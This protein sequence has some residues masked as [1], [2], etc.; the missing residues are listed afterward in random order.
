MF[1]DIFYLL[2]K[3]NHV[4]PSRVAI[5]V[6]LNKSTV[7]MWKKHRLSPNSDALQRIA[8]YFQVPLA[9][10]LGTGPFR[11]WD[12]IN[13]NRTLFF[14]ALSQEPHVSPELMPGFDLG[15]P[16]AVATA[17]LARYIDT[18]V[19]DVDWDPEQGFHV[20]VKPILL[21]TPAGNAVPENGNSEKN[22]RIL[23]LLQQQPEAVQT[24]VLRMLE[25]APPNNEES[26]Q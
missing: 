19:E 15:K 3:E 5:D 21:G 2:C 6:G 23:E 25:G 18:V 17:D 20:A 24:M 1:F 4:A 22:N 7:S 10:L 9:F 14:E 8:D 16:Q 11:N 26:G 12:A 13:Q